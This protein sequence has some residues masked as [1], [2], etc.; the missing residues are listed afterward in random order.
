MALLLK[1]NQTLKR[2]FYG[3]VHGIETSFWPGKSQFNARFAGGTEHGYLQV[4][5]P[6]GDLSISDELYITIEKKPG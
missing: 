3:R 6:N 2:K 4:I 5:L 1:D